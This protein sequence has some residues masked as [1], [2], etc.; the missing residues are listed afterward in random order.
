M[1]CMKENT[2]LT[3]PS[4]QNKLIPYIARALIFMNFTDNLNQKYSVKDMS[5][6]KDPEVKRLHALCSYIKT[7]CSW[8]SLQVMLNTRELCGGHGY[9]SYSKLPLLLRD[10]NVQI[11]WEGTNDV[12]IQQ[13]AKFLLANFS[14]YIQKGEVHDQSL[15]FLNLL[16]NIIYYIFFVKVCFLWFCCVLPFL[17]LIFFC[18]YH[19]IE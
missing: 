14:K 10:Q 6:A 17:Y 1:T 18:V 4:V 7:A 11:T 9:S 15:K 5:N 2:L 16:K 3:Y 19:N 12:L 8:D 13:T